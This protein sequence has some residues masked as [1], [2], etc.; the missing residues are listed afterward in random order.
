MSFSEFINDFARHLARGDLS[1]ALGD[2]GQGVGD[3]VGG[4]PGVSLQGIGLPGISPPAI[5]PGI[6]GGGQQQ[7]VGIGQA[8]G[9]FRGAAPEVCAGSQQTQTGYGT[10]AG[11][12]ACCDRFTF[13]SGFLVDGAT[14][15]IWKFNQEANR[16][17]EVPVVRN[18]NKQSLIDAM[19]ENKLSKIRSMYENEVLGTVAPAQRPKMLADFETTYLA[20]LRNAAKALM[21]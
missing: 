15:S 4:L 9:G 7:M 2:I 3:V 21:Y 10:V 20:P 19:V 13:N 16:F 11:P 14:G 1:G 17:D 8:G 12:P 5:H 6:S 18:P